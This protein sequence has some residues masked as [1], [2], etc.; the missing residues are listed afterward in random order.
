LVDGA[1][2]P[3][4]RVAISV[5]SRNDLFHVLG[6]LNMLM[7]NHAN[8]PVADVPSLRDFFVRHFGFIPYGNGGNDSFAV[9]RG[10]NGFILNV[11][12]RSPGDPETYPK[13]FHVGFMVGT[14]AEVHA[15]H[16]RLVAAG[17]GVGDVE[18]M[19]R[20]GVSSLTF[21][22]TA[23]NGILVEVSCYDDVVAS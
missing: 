10:E 11:M 1:W 22:C 4:A 23:P 15:A 18:A 9:M 5:L 3:V 16:D 13:N 20:R 8:L 21:Y 6:D 2:R 12:K 17:V 14:S 7:L 19:T